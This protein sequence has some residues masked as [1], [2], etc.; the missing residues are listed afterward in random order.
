MPATPRNSATARTG[1][2]RELGA[3]GSARL[4]GGYGRPRA[5]QWAGLYREIQFAL[6][7]ELSES[8]RAG[9]NPHAHLVFSERVNDGRARSTE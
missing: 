8:Q 5:G 1:T 9:E 2:F 6:S 7:K 4:L 3:R